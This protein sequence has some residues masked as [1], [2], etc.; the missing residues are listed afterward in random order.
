M[1]VPPAAEVRFQ[2][3]TRDALGSVPLE[4]GDS[5]SF[6]ATA[7]LIHES[8]EVMPLS[9]WPGRDALSLE[10][11]FRAPAR[12]GTWRVTLDVD[13]H[14]A[15]IP[16]VVDAATTPS[17]GSGAPAGDIIES[18]VD[19]A[20]VEAWVQSRGGTTITS[21]RLDD[22][23]DALESSLAVERRREPWHPMRSPWWMLPFTLALAGEWWL[24]RRRG[25]P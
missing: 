12:A 18:G 2:A 14:L 17:V 24:R 15:S 19:D 3:W 22:L 6:L 13:G 8:G 4:P 10:G 9:V 25:L 20:L 21:D 7:S 1:V 11:R 5:V 23:V 16:L